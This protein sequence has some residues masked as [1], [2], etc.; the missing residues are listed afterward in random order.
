MDASPR[1]SDSLAWILVAVVVV[2]MAIPALFF[3]GSWGGT[4]M[5]G[6]TTGMWGWGLLAMVVVIVVIVLVFALFVGE[7]GSA[8]VPY[9][10]PSYTP[11]AVP[12]PGSGAL[13]VLDARYAR[14]EITRDEYLRMRQDLEPRRQ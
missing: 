14:G 12:P 13:E 6:G 10:C 1:R 2:A 4:S 8:P 5:M 7:G 11:T 9:P 3:M